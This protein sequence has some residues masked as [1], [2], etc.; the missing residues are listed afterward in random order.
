MK[1]QRGSFL[2]RSPQFIRDFLLTIGCDLRLDTDDRRILED[3]IF[4][5]ILARQDFRRILFVGCDWFTF[6]YGRMFQ[7]H[8]FWTIDID[9][10]HRKY[11]APQHVVDGAQNIREH[12]QKASFDVIVCNGVFGWGLNER[13][14]VVKAFQ[15]FQECLR[16]GGLFVLGWNDNPKHPKHKPFPPE[17]YGDHFFERMIFPPLRAWRHRTNNRNGHIFDFYGVRK[18]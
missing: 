5:F 7:G 13:S 15:G 6:G 16:P 10:F 8:E 4:P 11:G 2:L 1:I 3:V 9:K 12:F 14:Q 18:S 17:E